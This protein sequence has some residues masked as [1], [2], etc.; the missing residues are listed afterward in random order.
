MKVARVANLDVPRVGRGAFRF[1]VE[2]V[3]RPLA[4]VSASPLERFDGRQELTR[5]QHQLEVEGS[6]DVLNRRQARVGG[7]AFE[8]RDLALPQPELPSQR[9]L[10]E[11][12]SLTRLSKH[13]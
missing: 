6:G 3:H 9:L 5:D 13:C 11:L 4:A 7:G 8:V 12:L 2:G 1:V 10:A